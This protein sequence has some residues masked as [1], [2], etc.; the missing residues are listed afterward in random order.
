MEKYLM[1]YCV[2]FNSENC[3]PEVKDARHV[4]EIKNEEFPIW[5]TG[6]EQIKLD[7]ICEKCTFRYFEIS[8]YECPACRSN[9]FQKVVK[10]SSIFDEQNKPKAEITFMECAKCK[11]KLRLVEQF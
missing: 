9:E 10:G 4:A 2:N 7:K 3:Q 8:K 5:P 1:D 6:D 11:S